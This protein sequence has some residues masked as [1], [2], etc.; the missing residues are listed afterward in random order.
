VVITI[1]VPLVGALSGRFSSYSMITIGSSFASLPVFLLALPRQWFQGL[2]DG[3][4]GH[5]IGH[6]WL[7]VEGRVD[8]LY[9]S[10]SLFVFFFSIG[11]AIWSPR[12]YEYTAAIAPKGKEGSYMAMSLLPYFVAKL[13]VGMLSGRLLQTYCPA[14]GPRHS[15]TLWLIV[16]L[17]ALTC[18]IG[19]FLFRNVIRGREEDRQ[20][21]A[22]A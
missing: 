10:V 6:V 21:P 4:L 19:M 5:L 7:G 16:G 9:V 17:M 12:L 2:A 20:A 13:F 22:P 1:L 3:W 18:P 11:E 15:E 8:P 14:E